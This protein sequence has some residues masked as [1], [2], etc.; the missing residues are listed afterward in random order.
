MTPPRKTSA[1]N[2]ESEGQPSK[3]S[4]ERARGVV[5]EFHLRGNTGLTQL[6][7]DIALALEASA[8]EGHR[9]GRKDGMLEALKLSKDFRSYEEN[10][11]LDMGERIRRQGINWGLEYFGAKLEALAAE[12]GEGKDG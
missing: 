6:E 1:A 5:R 12:Q 2:E 9:R 11:A 4:M 3:S 8:E 10:P 7:Q